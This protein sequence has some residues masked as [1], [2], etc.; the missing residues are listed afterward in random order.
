[1]PQA[2]SSAFA[3]STIAGVS[4]RKSAGC[5]LCDETT[6]SS[7]PSGSP[8]RS[9]RISSAPIASGSWPGAR[10]IETVAR[11]TAGMTVRASPATI[12]STSTAVSLPLRSTYSAP[13]P[14]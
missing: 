6:S 2:R 5:A 7:A 8:E 1:M 4:T 13:A 12:W 3:A 10:R 11:A 14:G 9:R